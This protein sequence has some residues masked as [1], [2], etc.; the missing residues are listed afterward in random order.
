MKSRII[1]LL[2]VRCARQIKQGQ[3]PFHGAIL[4]AFA[5]QTTVKITG[6]NIQMNI[7]R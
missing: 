1:C 7:T 5:H 3:H 6:E 4:S 2:L